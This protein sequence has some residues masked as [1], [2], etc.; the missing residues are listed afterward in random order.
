MNPMNHRMPRRPTPSLLSA[1]PLLLAAACGPG[2]PSLPGSE[3]LRALEP[4]TPKAEVLNAL[5]YGPLEVTEGDRRVSWGHRRSMYLQAGES[6]EVLWVTAPEGPEPEAS[7]ST[8]NPV[9]FRNDLLDG[10]GWEHFEARR[11]ELGLPVPFFERGETEPAVPDPGAV[12]PEPEPTPDV[13]PAD[14]RSAD[15]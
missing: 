7:R 12:D 5:P 2:E 1:L 11:A 8:V 3:A 4:G 10:W 14:G 6:I 9:M 13:S 15:G